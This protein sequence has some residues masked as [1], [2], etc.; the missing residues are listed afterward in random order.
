MYPSRSSSA[1]MNIQYRALGELGGNVAEI[2]MYVWIN[3][4][5]CGI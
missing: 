5:Y 2:S 3:M 4:Y 1:Y